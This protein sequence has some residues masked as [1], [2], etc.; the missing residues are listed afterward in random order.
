MSLTTQVGPDTVVTL[1]YTLFGEDG[2]VIEKTGEGEPGLEYVHGYGQIVPGLERAVEGM[3]AGQERSVVVPASAV[4]VDSAGEGVLYA[5]VPA[6]NADAPALAW[7][8]FG[9]AAQAQ[10]A[11]HLTEADQGLAL[12]VS[13]GSKVP[14]CERQSR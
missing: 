2:E 12:V 10:L 5:R 6:R 11:P 14:L 13:D 3:S 1:A 7:A 8:R 4:H 9:R